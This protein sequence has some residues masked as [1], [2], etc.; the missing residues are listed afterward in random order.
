MR[1]QEFREMIDSYLSDELL[2]ETNHEV[3]RHLESCAACRNE[4]AAHRTL[5][6]RVR[7]AVKGAPDAQINPYFARRLEMNL[8]ETALRPTVW[9]K[10]KSGAFLNSPILAATTAACLLFG[11]LFGVNWLRSASEDVVVRQNQTNKSAENLRPKEEPDTAQIVQ[12]AWREITHEAVGDHE[13]CALHFRL[14]EDP[15]TLKKAA[16]QYG[17]FNKDLDKTVIESLREV[18]S[19]KTSGKTSDKIQIFEAHSCVFQGKRF[20]HV[21]LLYRNRRISVLVTE[22][23]LP[24]ENDEKILSEA[25][26]SVFVARFR[27]TRHAVF[28]ISD[29][30]A[31]ENVIIAEALAPAVRR[32]IERSEAGA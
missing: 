26:K 10:I 20:A 9:T 23:N 13:N 29:L 18:F 27:T 5:R 31:G 8:R 3:L 1:C 16:D 28:V 7:A 4:L 24:G 2:V 15:I 22:A 19:E 11:V 25:I 21:I 14:K 17:K 30:T 12:A 6:T 32:H